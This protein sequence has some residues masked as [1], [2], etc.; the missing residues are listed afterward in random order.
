MEAGRGISVPPH[1]YTGTPESQTQMNGLSR[2]RAG[3]EGVG[4]AAL[5]DLRWRSLE[6]FPEL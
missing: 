3:G 4:L 2:Q 6:E 1:R 5:A